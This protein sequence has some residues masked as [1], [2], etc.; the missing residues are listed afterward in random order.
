MAF[1]ITSFETEYLHRKDI[2]TE[3]IM[4]RFLLILQSKKELKIENY[5]IITASTLDITDVGSRPEDFL[6]ENTKMMIICSH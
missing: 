1:L 2:T 5:L 6:Y 3:M 4:A